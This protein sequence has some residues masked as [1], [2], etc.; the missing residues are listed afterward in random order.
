MARVYYSAL[1]NTIRGLLQNT[2]YQKYKGTDYIRA[3]PVTVA[4]PNTARQIQI[5]QNLIT[6]TKAYYGISAQCKQLW[7]Q[8][9]SMAGMHCFGQQ[10]FIKL[11]A[12]LLNAS[13]DDLLC[14]D[15]PPHTPGTP[16]HVRGFQATPVSST[17]TCL[18]WTHPGDTKTY[19]TGHFRL[20][21]GFCSRFPSHGLCP[22]DGYRP[23]WRF[24]K[25]ERADQLHIIHNHSWPS[26]TRLY[27]FTN[28][29][30]EWGRKSPR[31]HAILV[32]VP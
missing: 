6:L 22:T 9:A 18:T 10:A 1:V 16:K 7:D 11:N 4:Q 19:V 17:V 25:T 3:A 26:G 15:Y 2:I 30:D 31:S 20:H 14:H 8:Y 13:H 24:V 23:S 29:I 28:S 21:R 27:Y 32:D 5:R 12:N